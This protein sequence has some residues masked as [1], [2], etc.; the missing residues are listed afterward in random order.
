MSAVAGALGDLVDCLKSPDAIVQQIAAMA[1]VH[2]ADDDEAR[3]LILAAGKDC[4]TQVACCCIA[5]KVKPVCLSY[6]VDK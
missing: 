5:Q 2:L 4:R 6:L 3:N 1:L